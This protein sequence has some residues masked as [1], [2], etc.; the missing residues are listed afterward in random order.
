VPIVFNFVERYGAIQKHLW[1]GKGFIM[2]GFK[3]GHVVVVSGW[4]PDYGQGLDG[5]LP[6]LD[7]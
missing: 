2:L 4:V 7:G 6:R 5:L 1:F 3:S